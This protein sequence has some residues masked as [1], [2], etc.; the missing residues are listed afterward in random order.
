M[1]RFSTYLSLALTSSLF[2]EEIST[3]VDDK[4]AQEVTV[5][6]PEEN[7]VK[8]I[9][10]S[11]DDF[12]SLF[13]DESPQA[14]KPQ[15]T[16]YQEES[17]TS[18]KQP[19]RSA[20]HGM[21]SQEEMLN[22]SKNHFMVY[23]DFLYWQ[24]FVNDATWAQQSTTDANYDSFYTNYS[25]DFSWD[26]GFRV[27][28]LYK[29]RWESLIFDA[30]WTH[31]YTTST[32]TVQNSSGLSVYNI[33]PFSTSDPSSKAN[34]S[35]NLKFDQFDF[36]FNKPVMLTKRFN[37][38]PFIGARGLVIQHKLNVSQIITSQDPDITN[39]INQKNN[40]YGIGLV[41]GLNSRIKLGK[42]FGFH[43][44]GDL[45]IG[46]GSNNSYL[47]RNYT[48]E[49]VE[50]ETTSSDNYTQKTNSTK[51]MLDVMAGLDWHNQ[52]ADESFDFFVSAGY[53]FHYIF[54]SPTFL[55][56][57]LNDTNL[58]QSQN[59]GFQGLTVRA[60]FGF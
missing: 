36:C 37:L 51:S 33:P 7:A 27:G 60:G 56:P 59:F 41:S 22:P 21:M 16:Y 19:S 25:F 30:N 31:F 35:Y 42:G 11:S 39:S 8:E 13:D 46:Y 48:V 15:K 54:N 34:A 55:N 4:N 23:G 9:T 12:S 32:N 49:G 3:Q 5:A 52:P 26:Y 18:Y 40:T 24:P 45:F 58:S 29:T 17:T 2:C 50:I 53:E 38:M 57:S 20:D 28:A 44:V 14:A 43:A 10:K 6:V 47:T 1:F